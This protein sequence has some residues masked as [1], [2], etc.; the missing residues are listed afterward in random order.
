[1]LFLVN[2][3]G[4]YFQEIYESITF[5]LSFVELKIIFLK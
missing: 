1:M 4:M 2:V 3:L 5:A